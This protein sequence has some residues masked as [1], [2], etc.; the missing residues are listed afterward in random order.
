MPRDKVGL[1][2]ADIAADHV[3][4]GVAQDLLQAEHVPA[5]DEVAAGE[6]VAEGVGAAARGD[7]RAPPE[8]RDRELDALP[9]ERPAPAAHEHR[10][11]RA[12]GAALRDVAQERP[13]G[14]RAEGH[15]PLLGALAHDP[16]RPVG[17][18][19][20]DPEPRHLGQPQAGVEQEQD[21]GAL[22]GL[23][24]REQ[25]LQLGVGE[26][27]D[28]PARDA[29]PPERPE[30]GSGAE[31]FCRAP[32]AED[33][34]APDV[35]GDRLGGQR[36]AQLE[37]P[38]AQLGRPDA[39]GGRSAPNR[40]TAW[41]LMYRYHSI[42]RGDTPSAALAARNRSTAAPRPTANRSAPDKR[43]GRNRVKRSAPIPS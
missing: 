12:D 15:D 2:Q 34:E 36:F 13:A 7:A 4:R 33:L 32:V 35:A 23:G 21:E 20:A 1:G 39:V 5:V 41:P 16:H 25:P 38:G 31:L 14:G 11:G 6:R 9:T 18:Q 26:G 27:G 22:A 43:S 8:V 10:V 24:D 3:E 19:V 40:R 42:V 37:Q 30:P 17:P 28:D 29:R